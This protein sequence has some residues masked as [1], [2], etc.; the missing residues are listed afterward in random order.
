MILEISQHDNVA[1]LGGSDDRIIISPPIRGRA[2]QC[3][4][5]PIVC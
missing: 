4:V 5:V 2:D 1:V 3:V